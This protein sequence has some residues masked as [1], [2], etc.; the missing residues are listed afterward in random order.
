MTTNQNQQEESFEQIESAEPVTRVMQEE[1][2]LVTRNNMVDTDLPV[3][4]KLYDRPQ[5][6]QQESA[7]KRFERLM[8]ND[9]ESPLER[10][11]FFCSL[12]MNDQD[13]VDVE[14]FFDALQQEPVNAELLA[15]AKQVVGTTKGCYPELEAAMI[16]AAL[17]ENE[18]LKGERKFYKLACEAVE[19]EL[20]DLQGE[21]RDWA[22]DTCNI[23]Y[24]GPP[25][26]GFSCV[27]CP[28]CGGNTAPKSTVE[29]LRVKK[30]L[31][32]ALAEIEGLKALLDGT[33]ISMDNW[34]SL[35]NKTDEQLSTLKQQ[36]ESAEPVAWYLEAC[37]ERYYTNRPHEIHAQ[38]VIITD[39]SLWK[40]LYLHP[41][42][43]PVNAELL[44]ALKDIA[45]GNPDPRDQ[46]IAQAAILKAEQQIQ[47][48]TPESNF[49]PESSNEDSGTPG[50]APKTIECEEFDRLLDYHRASLLAPP[51]MPQQT[52]QALIDFINARLNERN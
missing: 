34:Y 43:Q 42:T 20:A 46:E 12:A 44:A 8:Q 45:E 15:A 30:E 41:A 31:S 28:Q 35:Y 9:Q 27:V 52:K 1:G 4:T 6:P 13:W 2:S 25:Q 23:V 24:P 33:R 50:V 3:G 10:L 51:P 22:C 5:L 14:P 7:M 47:N 29:L 11:R 38:G 18:R 49:S 36:I 26:K 37:G 32:V 21:I 16:S 39:M 19:S 48:A 40:P 17:A